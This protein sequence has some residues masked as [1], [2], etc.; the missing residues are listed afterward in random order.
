MRFRPGT[1]LLLL[2]L[3]AVPWRA[4]AAL[5]P[6]AETRLY[7]AAF[8]LAE[9]KRYAKARAESAKGNHRLLNKFFVWLDLSHAKGDND[10]HELIAF[11]EANA[12][13]PGLAKLQRRAED[14]LP[15]DLSDAQVLAWFEGRP[16]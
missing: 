3:C 14:I 8:Q 7:D 16:P 10:F 6:E 15:E 2:A 12:H 13:W 4:Q 11:L 5:L 1:V 9:K